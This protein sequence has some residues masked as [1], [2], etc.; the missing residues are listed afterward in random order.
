[1]SYR[2]EMIYYGYGKDSSHRWEEARDG[3]GIPTP[4][5]FLVVILSNTG[6]PNVVSCTLGLVLLSGL[7]YTT[8]VH[9]IEANRKA[10]QGRGLR[11]VG[12]QTC[13]C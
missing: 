9:T 8:R 2:N 4:G 3:F 12:D 5:F 11:D 13:P 10:E 6:N 1:M 7:V